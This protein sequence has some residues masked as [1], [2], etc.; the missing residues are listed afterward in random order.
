MR[1]TGKSKPTIYRWVNAGQV[2]CLK[3]GT[4]SWF[5]L[6]DLRKARDDTRRG[7]PPGSNSRL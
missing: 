4:V 3:P 7:R 2:R 5:N 1:I 6:A